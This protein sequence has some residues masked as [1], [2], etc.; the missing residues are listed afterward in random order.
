MHPQLPTR[1]RPQP[2]LIVAII[3]LV[4]ATGGTA[5]ALPGR[6]TIDRNDVAKNAIRS[7]AI[8]DGQITGADLRDGAV[9]SDEIADGAIG[10]ADLAKGAVT[11]AE[12]ADGAVAGGDLAQGAVGGAQIAEGAVGRGQ[13]ANGAV[14]GEQIAEGVIGESHIVPMEPFTSS[15]RRAS[16]SSPT[17]ARATACGLTISSTPGDWRAQASPRTRSGASGSRASRQR[18]T[19]PGAMARCDFADP[20]ESEDGLAFALPSGWP[21]R[22][23]RHLGPPSG[24]P[25]RA[26]RRCGVQ[27]HRDPARRR[28]QR[29]Q[30]E[31]RAGRRVDPRGDQQGGCLGAA[32]R[33]SF[34]PSPQSPAEQRHARGSRAQPPT[35]RSGRRMAAGDVHGRLPCLRPDGR[36]HRVPGPITAS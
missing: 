9:T 13:I 36:V 32:G 25:D 17:A 28:L 4:A 35:A 12:I 15:A 2:A 30:G 29:P 11:G 7:K 1:R 33:V 21:G 16:R 19:A 5:T 22:A 8:K 14:G 23:L 31:R 20:G 18:P 3:A 26:R 24:D 34:A 10:G 6:N 27:R